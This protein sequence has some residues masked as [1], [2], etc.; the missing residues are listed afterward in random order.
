M[1]VVDGQQEWLLGGQQAQHREH[2]RADR[3]LVEPGLG[4]GRVQER[5]GERAPLRLRELGA[6]LVADRREQVREPRECETDLALGR[7]RREHED[8]PLLRA[9][10]PFEPQR[11]LADPC[12]S[13]ESED[14]S[15]PVE[16]AEEVVELG[17]LLDATH[18]PGWDY[19]GRR[20]LDATSPPSEA[21]S[22]VGHARACRSRRQAPPAVGWAL[23]GEVSEWSKERDWKSRRC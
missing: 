22:A 11:R 2:G 13:G 19:C 4:Q 23:L 5:R 14:G 1:G 15:A 3:P 9:A 12:L 8:P 18:D 10:D 20:G 16:R 17:Q 21:P 6:R 7:P